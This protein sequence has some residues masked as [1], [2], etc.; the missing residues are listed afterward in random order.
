MADFEI[1][2]H[3]EYNR[4]IRKFETTDPAHADLFNAVVQTLINNDEFL[5]RVVEKQKEDALDK[6]GDAKD[7]TVTFDSEDEEHPSGWTDIAPVTGGEKQS[8]L[9]QKVSLFT[10]N[11]RYLWK[12]C[13]T[14][15]ISGLADGTLTGAVSKLNTDLQN[16]HIKTVTGLTGPDGAGSIAY[17]DGFTMLN[18]HILSAKI[19][20]TNSEYYV[21][22]YINA[23][24]FSDRVY[25]YFQYGENKISFNFG[26]NFA[27]T[28]FEVVLSKFDV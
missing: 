4:S 16:I 17:P 28:T 10:K 15:D 24:M 21:F 18:A 25:I 27:N 5:K 19:R 6:T 7:T 20:F 23:D 3:P 9:W 12:L 14:N 1:P 8:S 22:P 2:E 11:V 26:K 13:G